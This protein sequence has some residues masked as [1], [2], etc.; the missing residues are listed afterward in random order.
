MRTRTASGAVVW[1]LDSVNTLK[2][3]PMEYLPILGLVFTVYAAFV[4]LFFRFVALMHRK[5]E[6]VL[7]QHGSRP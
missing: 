1:Y 3:V 4:L 6:S 7:R 2:G 5:E